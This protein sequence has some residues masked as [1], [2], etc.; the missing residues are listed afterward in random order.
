M[1]ST[2]APSSAPE[3]G[4]PDT[5]TTPPPDVDRLLRTLGP[6]RQQIRLERLQ[7]RLREG[8]IDVGWWRPMLLR[9]GARLGLDG[10]PVVTIRF[11]HPLREPPAALVDIRWQDDVGW[12][13][14]VR[15]FG[16]ERLTLLAWRIAV[17]G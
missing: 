12:V 11:Y 1:R 6:V 16:A 14:V 13:I 3:P 15:T 17:D 8:P 2:P 4:G 9:S 5:S 7:A 10:G